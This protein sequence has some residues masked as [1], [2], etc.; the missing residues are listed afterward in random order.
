MWG[1]RETGLGGHTARTFSHY[2]LARQAPEA[3]YE[4]GAG[5]EDQPKEEPAG[6]APGGLECGRGMRPRSGYGAVTR[7][8]TARPQQLC[9]RAGCEHLAAWQRP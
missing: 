3:G 4:H 9:A 6:I 5:K 7:M 1:F 8:L 2:F